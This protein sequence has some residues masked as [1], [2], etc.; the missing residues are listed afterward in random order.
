[1]LHPGRKYNFDMDNQSFIE[2]D[3]GLRKNWKN[4]VAPYQI[5][6]RW[7]SIWQLVNTLIPYFI[8]WGLMVWSL[9]FSY[10]LTLALSIPTAGFLMRIFIIFHDCGHGSFFKSKR[11]NA[12]TGFFTGILT[13]TAFEYW[14][15]DHAIHHATAGDLDRR[16][17]GDVQTLT[18]NEYLALPTWRRMIYRIMRQPFIMLVIGAPL[19]FLVVHRI[20]RPGVG[21]RERNSVIWTNLTLAAI[22]LLLS[23][24]IGL[25]AFLLVQLPVIVIGTAAGVWL[26]YVQHQFEGVYWRRHS[27][28]DYLD[29]AILGASYYKLPR[30]LQWFSGNIGYHH[31]HH[32]SP[33]IPNYNLERCQLDN[34]AFDCVRPLTLRASLRSL[35]LRLYDEDYRQLIGFRELKQRQQ[36][37]VA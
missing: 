7:S 37:Q 6:D 26:F 22:I 4:L 3:P 31:L 12:I 17:V 32:L 23:L 2:R 8:L 28:W 11:A 20:A 13:F 24:A 9:Q 30:L 25:K 34:P 19:V 16:G 27:E 29:S 35:R 15:R 36:T 33:R 21:R 10:W 18:V 5:P 14:T 1:M